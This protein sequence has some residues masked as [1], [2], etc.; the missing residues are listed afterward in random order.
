MIPPIN[1]E[2]RYEDDSDALLDDEEVYPQVL[3]N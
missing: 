3:G 2:N 1:G